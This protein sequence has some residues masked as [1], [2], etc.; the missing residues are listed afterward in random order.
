MRVETY[1]MSDSIRTRFLSSRLV[2][3][4]LI[5]VFLERARPHPEELVIYASRGAS[6]QREGVGRTSSDSPFPGYPGVSQSPLSSVFFIPK[7]ALLFYQ[8]TMENMR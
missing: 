4:L 2:A 1:L 3:Q 6:A 5:R 7:C 8:G